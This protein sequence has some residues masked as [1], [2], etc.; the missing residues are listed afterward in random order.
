MASKVHVRL[1]DAYAIF[2]EEG[3]DPLTGKGYDIHITGFSEDGHPV[4]PIHEVDL[5]N[6]VGA[7]IH[8]KRLIDLGRVPGGIEAAQVE[9][10]KE[11]ADF[12]ALRAANEAS[13]KGGKV[14]SITAEDLETRLA[15]AKAEGQRLAADALLGAKK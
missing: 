2:K 9:I 15:A 1:A 8:E 10:D 7:A 5:T 6:R 11:L 13:V 3:L 4:R 12:R 14:L